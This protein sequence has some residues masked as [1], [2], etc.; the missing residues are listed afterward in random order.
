MTRRLMLTKIQ[1]YNVKQ[2]VQLLASGLGTYFVISTML[3]SFP[4]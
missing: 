4:K 2:N 1:G 3:W